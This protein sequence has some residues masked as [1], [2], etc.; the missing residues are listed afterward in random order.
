MLPDESKVH[1]KKI[2]TCKK[3]DH[4]LLTAHFTVKTSLLS[5]RISEHGIPG[6]MPLYGS[7]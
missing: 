2:L 4:P 5:R 1:N 3:T 6:T 7:A